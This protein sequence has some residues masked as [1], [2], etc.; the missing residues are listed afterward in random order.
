MIESYGIYILINAASG[1]VLDL[2]G[3]MH[4]G[5]S[6]LLHSIYSNL[7]LHVGSP[8]DNTPCQGWQNFSSLIATFGQQWLVSVVQGD[9]FTLRNLRGGTYLNMSNGSNADGTPV[10]GYSKAPQFYEKNQQWK[11]IPDGAYYR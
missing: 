7:P 8:A 9:I 2:A 4:L 10:Q 6:P 5:G 11:V 3:G 1:T